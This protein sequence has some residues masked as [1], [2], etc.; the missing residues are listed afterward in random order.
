MLVEQDV[1]RLEVAV[2]DALGVKRADAFCDL[3]AQRHGRLEA[4]VPSRSILSWSVPPGI[5]G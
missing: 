2:D 3:Q 4:E 1:R 5:E